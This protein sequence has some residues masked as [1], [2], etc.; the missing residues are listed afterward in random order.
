MSTV[1]V[2]II[3][4]AVLS[5]ITTSSEAWSVLLL[6]WTKSV[7]V[8]MFEDGIFMED[9]LFTLGRVIS[10][11]VRCGSG[12]GNVISLSPETLS[13]SRFCS[14]LQ[15]PA[16]VSLCLC[17]RTLM[18][19]NSSFLHHGNDDQP[20]AQGGKKT[21]KP[22][23][24]FWT[25]K[26]YLGQWR[27]WWWCRENW[28]RGS[29]EVGPQTGQSPQALQGGG[30]GQ[31]QRH[32]QLPGLA[33]L[34]RRGKWDGLSF[35]QLKYAYIHNSFLLNKDKIKN[36]MIYPSIQ[37]KSLCSVVNRQ[38]SSSTSVCL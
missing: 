11:R 35:H 4:V 20:E 26:I 36:R 33:Q 27:R 2:S 21:L 1:P 18:K 13:L 12:W 7:L 28:F 16:P 15:S 22:K 29:E 31:A 8:V 32:R 34:L 3:L 25:N 6:H 14:V 30:C 10:Q 37:T 38:L 5:L 9:G 23:Q 24:I 17:F 19:R